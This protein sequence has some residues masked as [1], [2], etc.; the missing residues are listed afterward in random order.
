MHLPPPKHRDYGSRQSLELPGEMRMGL[1]PILVIAVV[2]LVTVPVLSYYSYQS[3]QAETELAERGTRVACDTWFLAEAGQLN[4]YASANRPQQ[5]GLGSGSAY[6]QAI[7]EVLKEDVAFAQNLQAAVEKKKFERNLK[8]R[9]ELTCQAK[10]SH[11]DRFLRALKN[12]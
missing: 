7:T 2:L 12:L 5:L 11:I 4:T 6:E 10:A 8:A 3:H 9:V 1:I